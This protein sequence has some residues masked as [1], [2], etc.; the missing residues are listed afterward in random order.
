M[1]AE[2]RS[3]GPHIRTRPHT[4]CPD[5][6]RA[7]HPLSIT[8]LVSAWSSSVQAQANAAIRIRSDF[9]AR[10]LPKR[11]RAADV[12]RLPLPRAYTRSAYRF[13]SASRRDTFRKWFSSRRPSI[14]LMTFSKLRSTSLCLTVT[15]KPALAP[16]PT[17]AEKR[18]ANAAA[19]KPICG[20]PPVPLRLRCPQ[21]LRR[22]RTRRPASLFA[23][24]AMPYVE[25]ARVCPTE[26]LAPRAPRYC[27]PT[28]DA[29]L[30]QSKARNAPHPGGL[31]QRK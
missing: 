30:P 6:R 4:R 9:E 27:R 19:R 12:H 23:A 16:C 18:L 3:E 29:S 24:A 28:A 26:T 17:G 31:P 14:G 13:P 2:P 8:R 11:L 5:S 20:R 22:P 21:P 25:E 15:N 1:L 10:N 7:V